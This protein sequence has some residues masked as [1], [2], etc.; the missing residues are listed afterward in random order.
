MYN[1]IFI[2]AS[3]GNFSSQ[4][5]PVQCLA[6][7]RE[8]AQEGDGNVVKTGLASVCAI[9]LFL[10]CRR[11]CSSWDLGGLKPLGL[12]L[13]SWFIPPVGSQVTFQSENSLAP[14]QGLFGAEP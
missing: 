8:G 10:C 6:M 3:F 13:R 4:W 2:C 12:R 9:F 14:A 1:L 7:G 11:A 5:V